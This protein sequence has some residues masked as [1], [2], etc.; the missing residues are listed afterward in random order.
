MALADYQPERSVVTY[1][2]GPLTSVRGLC[3]E[4]VTALVRNHLDDLRTL[5]DWW[6]QKLLR[7]DDV[8]GLMFRLLTTAPDTAAKM[9]A[10]ACDEPE[11]VPAAKRLSMPL[12]LKIMIEVYR[13]TF[14]DVGG[15]L[16]FAAMIGQA[17]IV[18]VPAAPEGTTIQ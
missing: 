3:F 4:D 11:G 10:L 5:Y 15:P 16:A 12:Q 14:E 18:A 9:I 7:P 17:M 1:K 6:Q 8:E 2:Q 13:L